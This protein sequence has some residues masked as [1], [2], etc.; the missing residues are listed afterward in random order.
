MKTLIMALLLLF[1]FW[2]T[3]TAE[4]FEIELAW[5]KEV[6]EGDL[7]GFIV[8]MADYPITECQG[9][10]ENAEFLVDVPYT[11][12]ESEW[13]TFVNYTIPDGTT[14]N[15]Y[16]RVGAYD[17]AWVTNH[18][19]C[20]NEVIAHLDLEPPAGCGWIECI[21]IRVYVPPPP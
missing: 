10:P 1:A 12:P 8:Y 7:K 2:G 18:S 17:N 19:V 3:S 21:V 4:T 15:V 20:S 6:I 16:I 5:D 13:T 11:P 14:K 9:K